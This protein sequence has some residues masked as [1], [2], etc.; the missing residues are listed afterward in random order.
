[1]ASDEGVRGGRGGEEGRGRKGNAMLVRVGDKCPWGSLC[2]FGTVG[3]CRGVHTL[4]EREHF[5]RKRQVQREEANTSCPFCVRGCC[6]FGESCWRGV[7]EDS[8][9]SGSDGEEH[10]RE[11]TGGQPRHPGG[12]RCEECAAGDVSGTLEE[13]EVGDRYG[14][15]EWDRHVGDDSGWVHTEARVARHEIAPRVGTLGTR[16]QVMGGGYYV[17]LAVQEDDEAPVQEQPGQVVEDSLQAAATQAAAQWAAAKVATADRAAAQQAAVQQA[18][19]Q[20]D[21]LLQAVENEIKETRA[22]ARQVV[23]GQAAVQADKAGRAQVKE[24]AVQAAAQQAAAQQAAAQQAVG[25]EV[26]VQQVRAWQA[27]G[28]QAAVQAGKTGR[29]QVQAAAVQE[30]KGQGTAQVQ[31]TRPGGNRPGQVVRGGAHA[32]L[33]V[34]GCWRQWRKYAQ[35]ARYD[36]E[37]DEWVANNRWFDLRDAMSVWMG[38]YD[39]ACDAEMNLMLL[40]LNLARDEMRLTVWMWKFNMDEAVQEAT[41]SGWWEAAA[42]RP[43]WRQQWQ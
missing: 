30:T 18:V 8:D 7:K 19:A 43:I 28:M 32:Q 29:A 26:K 36:D 40:I 11:D 22:W 37:Y 27:A 23:A 25:N 39:R 24:A 34:Q 15:R 41:L 21:A 1:M 5:K 9:Y 31:A 3:K 14:V 17:A 38:R 12:T 6:R 42:A 4:L 10:T 16:K 20:Q 13:G 35:V 33:T 2:R